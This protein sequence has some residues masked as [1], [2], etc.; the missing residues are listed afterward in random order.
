MK[1]HRN[2]KSTDFNVKFKQCQMQIS[3][4]VNKV[5]SMM[6]N[7][8]LQ[9]IEFANSVSKLSNH[10]KETKAKIEARNSYLKQQIDEQ[11]RLLMSKLEV[12]ESNELERADKMRNHH[13][14][15]TVKFQMFL[16]SS[17]VLIDESNPSSDLIHLADGVHSQTEELVCHFNSFEKS[18]MEGFSKVS[19][20]ESDESN[21]VGAIFVQEPGTVQQRKME[22]KQ[23]KNIE[24]KTSDKDE[25]Q[26]TVNNGGQTTNKGC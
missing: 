5:K 9:T 16:R 23:Q 12:L 6:A 26:T 2:H 21:A 20:E 13:D 1:T 14:D 18:R 25:G 19:F 22:D 24:G 10:F 17:E 8:S 11:S 3:G 15:I 7:V 4:D